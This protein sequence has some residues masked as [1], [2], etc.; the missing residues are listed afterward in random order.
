VSG[1]AFDIQLAEDVNLNG[2]IDSGEVLA[3]ANHTSISEH[4]IRGPQRPRHL[5][6]AR[7]SLQ[8]RKG[9]TRCQWRI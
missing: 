2:M 3:G 6:P 4:F 5:L 8:R 1:G 9:S 7:Q